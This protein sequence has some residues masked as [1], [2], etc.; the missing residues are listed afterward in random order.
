VNNP[1]VYA[2]LGALAYDISERVK[3]FGAIRIAAEVYG[4]PVSTT[5]ILSNGVARA[6]AANG[7]GLQ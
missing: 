5:H 4:L 2:A 1:E 7:S 3:S 6:I